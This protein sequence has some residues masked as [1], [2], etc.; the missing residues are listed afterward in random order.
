[1]QELP[2]NL[3]VWVAVLVGA[4]CEGIDSLGLLGGEDSVFIVALNAR[5]V[6][7]EILGSGHGVAVCGLVCW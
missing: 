1:M 7:L 6:A 3:P 4:V 5:C 2:T